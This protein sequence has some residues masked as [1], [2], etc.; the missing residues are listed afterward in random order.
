MLVVAGRPGRSRFHSSKKGKWPL[1]EGGA[2]RAA[3]AANRLERARRHRD[4]PRATWKRS[5]ST[6]SR[7]ATA[8]GSSSMRRVISSR[9]AGRPGGRE[10]DGSLDGPIAE[11]I[12]A[13]SPRDYTTRRVL[14]RVPFRILKRQG[15]AARLGAMDYVIKG[16]MIA[17][18]CS[19]RMAGGDGGSGSDV[20][21]EPRRRR[22]EKDSD[23]IRQE[24]L[25]HGSLQSGEDWR[26]PGDDTARPRA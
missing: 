18:I 1:L 10:P 13:A 3:R 6:R 2:A 4:L 9:Q 8:T 23:A 26:S 22:P 20:H 12:A 21:R 5:R 14:S 24:R 15:P 25:S 19:R 16:Q 7:I 17:A 11:G